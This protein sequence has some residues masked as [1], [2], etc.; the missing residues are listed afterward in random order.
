[1]SLCCLESTVTK[2][3]CMW[4]IQW[5]NCH[6]RCWA[7]LR[8]PNTARIW[9]SSSLHEMAPSVRVHTRSRRLWP[10]CESSRHKVHWLKRAYFP[11]WPSSIA[12]LVKRNTLDAYIRWWRLKA[13]RM[14]HPQSATYLLNRGAYAGTDFF[15]CPPRQTLQL[16]LDSF[17]CE[18]HLMEYA[19]T[20]WHCAGPTQVLTRLPWDRLSVWCPWNYDERHFSKAHR[21]QKSIIV[22]GVQGFE[23]SRQKRKDSQIFLR[24]RRARRALGNGS[25]CQGW[26]ARLGVWK[27]KSSSHFRRFSCL[28]VKSP[29]FDQCKPNEH[30]GNC[31]GKER[32][33]NVRGCPTKPCL[34]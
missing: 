24:L 10:H 26:R 13:G 4:S 28:S 22:W 3:C 17:R 20:A 15:H 31:F 30:A 21:R 9:F 16:F 6:L 19:R 14:G 7:Q 1:L 12:Q 8:Q 5:A 2:P 27:V 29:N 11:H 34:W 33:Q 18:H 23:W 32:R 25:H